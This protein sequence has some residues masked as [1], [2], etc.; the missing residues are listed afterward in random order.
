MDVPVH[1]GSANS[2]HVTKLI[3][4]FTKEKQEEKIWAY[5]GTDGFLQKEHIFHKEVQFSHQVFIFSNLSNP[6]CKIDVWPLK[7]IKLI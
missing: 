1:P 7:Q 5:D 2:A 6:Q 3:F 4:T